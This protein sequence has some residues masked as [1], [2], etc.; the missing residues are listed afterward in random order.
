MAPQERD[1]GVAIRFYVAT[2]AE[3]APRQR[4]KY[5]KIT[6]MRFWPHTGRPR[7]PP[8]LCGWVNLVGLSGEGSGCLGNDVGDCARL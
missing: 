2:L 1:D 7:G 4:P 3:S 5:L 6:I 8:G